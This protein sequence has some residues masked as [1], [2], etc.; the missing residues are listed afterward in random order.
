MES[1]TQAHPLRAVLLM[2]VGPLAIGCLLAPWIHE[3]LLALV[4][5]WPAL[6]ELGDGRFERTASRVVQI[7]A[8]LLVWPCMRW[9]GTTDRLGPALRWSRPRARAFLAWAAL[10]IASM[11][12]LYALGCARG[13]HFVDP[14]RAG[15]GDF[16]GM[17]LYFILGALLVGVLEEIF[18]RGFLF[19]SVSTR[20]PA[21]AAALF[22]SV[23]FSALHF[24]RPRLPVPIE[25]LTWSSGYA[26]VPHLFSIFRPDQDWPFA[27]TLF[28]MGLALC[29]FFRRSG[30][31]YGIA[32]L[33]TGWVWV[34]QTSDYILD[35]SKVLPN[36]WFGPGDLISR[37]YLAAAVAALFALIAWCLPAP[38]PPDTRDPGLVTGARNGLP[39]VS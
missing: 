14:K 36:I 21:F 39:Q 1:P 34:L 17:P 23:V 32:G 7:V 3:G 33:H 18:F 26:L 31:L 15:L 20:L 9:S 6:H 5:R 13:L 12:I 11:A 2:L 22:S 37:G 29:G 10:G 16:L 35:R 30:H 8:L 24:M 19:G 4:D 28:F 38:R 27:V 25:D